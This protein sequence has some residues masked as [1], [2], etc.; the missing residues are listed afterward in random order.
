[1]A[2]RTP[3]RI[4]IVLQALGSSLKWLG[5]RRA[6]VAPKR[7][8]IAHHLLLGDTIMLTPLLA[9]LRERYPVAEIVMTVPRASA[10]LYQRQPYGVKAIPYDLRDLKSVHQLLRHRGFD[11]AFVPGDNRYSWL[12][13]A[14]DARWVVAFAGDRPAYKSWPVDELVPYPDKP[15]AWGDLVAGLV[16]GPAPGPYEP[17]QWPAPDHEPFDAPLRNYCVLH[18]GAS[19]PLKLWEA[20]KWREL[21]ARLEQVG[22]EIVWS[23]GR[24]EQDY[25]DR[26]DSER[27]HSSFAGKLDLAQ[28]WRL[29]QDASI[30]V[31]PDTGIAHLGRVAG[32]PTVVL[33]G[34]GSHIVSG[35][36][37]FWR[38]APSCSITID[39]FP[40]R[41]QRILFKR[42]I[43]WVRRC[44][45]RSGECID[46]RCMR[47]I[48]VEQVLSMA[49]AL[50]R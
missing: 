25:V 36:G 9:K 34:P 17:S 18:V 19:T 10:V 42:E 29:I 41:D 26:I 39:P 13:R 5:R 32:A 43:S 49:K 21:A 23:A 28:L 16:A 2:S 7:I 38:N 1:M 46:N 30:L 15:A 37:E 48:S 8:L 40:C 3:A 44:Q 20:E 45:R 4:A 47:S 24:G 35:G 27:R 31:S 12:A 11:L 50:L 22:Y 33:F 6:P 14:L